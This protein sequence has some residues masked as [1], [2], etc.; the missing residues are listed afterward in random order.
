MIKNVIFD[1]GG[2]LIDIDYDKTE[3]WFR[4]LFGSSVV[5]SDQFRS[6]LEDYEI[7]AFSEG[8]FLHRL[9]R[10]ST[11]VISERQLV[12]AW[13][14]MIG[15]MPAVRLDLLRSLASDYD[16]YLLS[17]TN[18]THLQYV[19]RYLDKTYGISDFGEEFFKK[20]YFSHEIHL[21]KPNVDIYNYVIGDASIDPSESLFID[22]LADNISGAKEAGLQGV[23]HDRRVDINTVIDGYLTNAL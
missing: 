6:I 17:N 10:L 8:S 1:F 11:A 18:L 13:N 7:G 21:R 19:Y 5:Q 16:V 22:D 14:A 23:I 2:V 20:A 4:H 15:D 3:D 12:D 9:Q